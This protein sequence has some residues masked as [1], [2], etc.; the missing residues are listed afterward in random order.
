MTSVT[1]GMD[2]AG[3]D[4]EASTGG[5]ITDGSGKAWDAGEGVAGE[6][7]SS[8]A[9]SSGSNCG[10]EESSGSGLSGEGLARAGS[11]GGAT[12]VGGNNIAGAADRAVMWDVNR[13]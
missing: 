5:P 3:I 8:M 6:D 4:A 7:V 11:Q 12:R 2:G 10:A 1:K 9:T 13:A